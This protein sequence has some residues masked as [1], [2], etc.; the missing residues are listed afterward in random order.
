MD[1]TATTH[2]KFIRQALTIPSIPAGRPAPQADAAANS[3][4]RGVRLP[5]SHRRIKDLITRREMRTNLVA[6]LRIGVETLGNLIPGVD[7]AADAALLAT[8]AQ[9]IS[10]Y[11]QMAV[12]ATAALDFVKEAPY[13]L[14]DLQVSSSYQEFPSYADFVKSNLS[15]QVMTKM[16]GSAGDGNQYHHIVT[17]GGLNATNIPQQML[18][19]TDNIIMLPTLLHEI[20]TDEYLGPSPDP[21]MNLYQWLQTQSYGVQREEGLRILGELHILK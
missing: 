11:R 3:A 16:F 6:A 18:Q 15:T 13:S 8:L 5:R 17:Q 9:T 19:N 4:Q 20:V 21:D 7:V 10:E 14:E 2:A 1:V 12:E